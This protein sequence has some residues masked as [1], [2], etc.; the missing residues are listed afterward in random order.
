MNET[1]NET[2]KKSELTL[3]LHTAFRTAFIMLIALSVAVCVLFAFFPALPQKLYYSLDNYPQAL[4]Y[5][6]IR[7][8]SLKNGDEEA[9]CSALLDEVTLTE[10]LY[11]EDIE[12]AD[13]LYK[14]AQR[15][16]DAPLS[17]T[18][19]RKTDEF[20]Y[21]NSAK[22]YRAVVY[23]NEA[24]LRKLAF[25]GALD[26]KNESGFYVREDFTSLEEILSEK[27]D[28]TFQKALEYSYLFIQLAER[29]KRDVETQ[30]PEAF[31]EEFRA[32]KDYA[33]KF[34]GDE[35]ALM[36]DTPL[37]QLYLVRAAALFSHQA[38]VKIGEEWKKE[39]RMDSGEELI[40]YYR[41]TLL[42]SYIT[43]TIN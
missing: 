16:L 18:F 19:N 31:A 28:G 9:Y 33:L 36:N 4:R 11:Y 39:N 17:D 41:D 42:K 21:K 43:T 26:S 38:E 15:L 7:A 12:Y 32:Y 25:L 6:R 37:A 40:E 24:Y 5:A 14:S 30:L 35:A 8:Q 3:I 34:E 2:E 22:S 13:D 23:S 29:L 27:F 10:K 20:N 1:L